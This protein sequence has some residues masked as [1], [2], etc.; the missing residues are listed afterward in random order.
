MFWEEGLKVK[1]TV[2]EMAVNSG[3]IFIFGIALNCRH[4]TCPLLPSPLLVINRAVIVQVIYFEGGWLE[5][6]SKDFIIIYCIIHR[7]CHTDLITNFTN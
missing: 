5:G 2:E 1:F 3:Q 6:V 4:K 7:I